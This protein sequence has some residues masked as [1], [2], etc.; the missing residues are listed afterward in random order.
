MP[1]ATKSALLV[2]EI[3]KWG[4]NGIPSQTL[5]NSNG[6]RRVWGNHSLQSHKIIIFCEN[7]GKFSFC[8]RITDISCFHEGFQE[9][10][11]KKLPRTLRFTRVLRRGPEFAVSAKNPRFSW[12][13]SNCHANDTKSRFGTPESLLSPR[14]WLTTRQPRTR[15]KKVSVHFV[16]FTFTN[17]Y[18]QL[19]KML[20]PF[21]WIDCMLW[22]AENKKTSPDCQSCFGLTIVSPDWR[23]ESPKCKKCKKCTKNTFCVSGHQIVNLGL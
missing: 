9:V 1:F 12:K 14:G 6:L 3:V 20:M 5:H 13:F 22:H 10:E 21:W 2:A 19:G 7:C 4:S 8:G 15:M 18:H 17:E 11:A 16:E 23:L